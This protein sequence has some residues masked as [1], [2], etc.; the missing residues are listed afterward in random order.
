MC[1]HGQFDLVLTHSTT[2][3]L[4]S[5]PPHSIPHLCVLF[6]G[7]IYIYI[8]ILSSRTYQ[9]IACCMWVYVWVMTSV[10]HLR[11]YKYYKY[12]TVSYTV[13]AIR[14]Q[15][16]R[17]YAQR[18][19]LCLHLRPYRFVLSNSIARRTYTDDRRKVDPPHCRSISAF[20]IWSA[21]L[22]WL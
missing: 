22:Q 15:R 8:Y 4:Y 17:I 12:C 20:Y 19:H 13:Y 1:D 14:M 6:I 11:P 9:H 3:S 21:L 16:L 18:P 2:N 7:Y 10:I 5:Y